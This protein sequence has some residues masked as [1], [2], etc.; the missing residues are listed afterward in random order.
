MTTALDQQPEV[1]LVAT[2]AL[3]IVMIS[4][5]VL[6]ALAMMAINAV[7]PAID[8]ALA[9]GPRD[10]MM[11]K[12]MLGGMGLAM[13]IGAPL[14]GFLVD[15]LGLRVMLVSAGLLYTLAGT[16]GLYLDSLPLLLASRMAL[17]LAAGAIQVISMTVINTS[18]VGPE[19]A[20]WMGM[21][22]SAAMLSAFAF[23]PVSGFLGNFGW[24]WPFALY[25]LGLLMLPIAFMQ[26]AHI[27]PLRR[28]ESEKRADDGPSLLR[29]FPYHYL[30]FA[31]V[32]G[33]VVFL[34]TAF[35]PFILRKMG[36]ASPLVISLVLTADSVAG[37]GMA[38]LYGRARR[39]LSTH[40]AF[41]VS[42]SLTSVGLAIAVLAPATWM[43][44]AGVMVYGVG[45]G[46]LDAN[47]VTAVS[48]KVR[49][50][51]QGRAAGLIKAAHFAAA[52]IGIALVEPISRTH[53]PMVALAISGGLSLFLLVLI[54]LRVWVKA[55]QLQPA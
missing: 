34:P 51:Q 25:F 26:A 6:V 49:P 42:F 20:K 45:F 13:V 17:G 19:R 36:F 28:V 15:R 8:T 5:G 10:S 27:A 48:E 53:G 24:R 1:P 32:L 46:W 40:A 22:I 12:Q 38:L 47:I 7:L 44:I 4:G 41:I 16:V 50:N 23:H 35:L 37:I 29:T 33:L 30:P 55:P 39:H 9:H 52:P 18:L 54:L 31:I 43:F 2:L 3:R 14:G 21:H 11:V